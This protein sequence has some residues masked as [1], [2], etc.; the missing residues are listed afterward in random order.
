M[1]RARAR[2]SPAADL[3]ARNASGSA[4]PPA[5]A[6][7]NAGYDGVILHTSDGGKTWSKQNAGVALSLEALF[8]RNKI[9][10]KM[11]N[12]LDLKIVSDGLMTPNFYW[13][14]WYDY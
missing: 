2:P 6:A 13:E 12:N 1:S 11:Q 7:L 14:L 10:K 9:I 8:P 5:T 4:A 3:S